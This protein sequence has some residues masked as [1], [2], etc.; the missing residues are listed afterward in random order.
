MTILPRSL[1]LLIGLRLRASLR[2]VARSART[3]RGV[4]VLLLGGGCIAMG[5]VPMV[6]S[7]F[8]RPPVAEEVLAAQRATATLLLPF[9]ILGFAL[10]SVARTSPD[11]ALAFHQAEVDFLFPAPFSRTQLLFYKL[12]QRVV[13]LLFV[14]GFFLI[15]G[16]NVGQALLPTWFGILLSLWFV[17]LLAL[18]LALAGQKFEAKRFAWWRRAGALAVVLIV[19]AGSAWMGR[20]F[21]MSRPLDMLRAFSEST[22]GTLITLP[23]QPFAKVIVASSLFGDGLLPAL[24]A[25]SVNAGLLLIAVRLDAH[26][27]E[28]GAESSQRVA[29][30]VAE[31]QRSGG[32]GAGVSLPGLRLPMFPRLGGIG[33]LS[34]RQAVSGIRQG[35]RGL[36]FIAL[37]IGSMMVPQFLMSSGDGKPGA[38]VMAMKPVGVVLLVYLS[39]FMPQILRLDFRADIDRMDL[40]K[41]LPLP[42]W[43]V[44]LAQLVVPALIITALQVPL[45]AVLNSVLGWNIPGF[46]LLL[47]AIAVAAAMG[48]LLV[49]AVENVV[50]LLWPQRPTRGAGVQFSA[51]QI[52]G[53]MLKM[54]ALGLMLAAAAGAGAAA[55]FLGGKSPLL[56]VVGSAVVLAIESTLAVMMVARLFARFD[57]A[58][59]QVADA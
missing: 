30:K 17:H 16:R 46:A 19:L 41:S 18:A 34:W 50:F 25:L 28:A 7:A 2:L 43:R 53:Q 33:P 3:P 37:I 12:A 29:A 57:P 14:S 45:A 26:W 13:P 47:P 22:P 36:F 32:F 9:G 5:L 38:A 56:A 35:L 58:T 52:V 59:E 10:L 40:L 31:I 42:A 20:T 54:F 8:I 11:G 24:I 1:L 23:T 51:S 48:N 4:I 55:F 21:D 27:L 6:I 39:L 44:A 15:W 49:A